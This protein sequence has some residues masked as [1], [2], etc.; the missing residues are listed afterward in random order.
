MGNRVQRV[1]TEVSEPQ[2]AQAIIEAWRDMFGTV[3]AKEQVALVLA[4]NSLETGARKSMWNYNIGNITTNGKDSYDY[5]DDLKTDEQITPGVWKKMNLKYR[6]YP[7]LKDGA[8]D[9]L[10]LLSSKHYSNAWEHIKNPDPAAFSKA[11][12]QSGYYTANEAPYTKTLSSLFGK[13]NKS[14]AYEVARSG[15]VE[16]VKDT[17]MPKEKDDLMEKYLAHQKNTGYDPYAELAGHS[18]PASS[19]SVSNLDGILNSFLQQISAS[20]KLNKKLYKQY[21]PSNNIVITIKADY[22][23]AIEFSRILC[24][25]LNEE[26]VADAFT[27]GDEQTIEVECNIPGP[28]EDC[29][30]AVQQLT[31]AVASAF[32]KATVKIGGIEVKTQF[33]MNKKSS[34]EEIS[35]KTAT[36]QYRKFLLKFV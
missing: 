3:P 8:K 23:N 7:T 10:K 33:S 21:L 35:V 2:M 26:L 11:L 6:A 31:N 28:A 14:N 27:H 20:E 15:K 29:Y 17:T 36:N 16:P 30:K 18:T 5:F 24:T 25:A 22:T 19:P 1:R 32:K 12:K 34:Y 9:Y 13:Y 4:Q